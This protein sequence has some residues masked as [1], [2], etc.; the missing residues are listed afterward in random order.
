MSG[1]IRVDIAQACI[2]AADANCTI[3]VAAA[4]TISFNLEQQ[5]STK[6][7]PKRYY[8]ENGMGFHEDDRIRVKNDK[9]EQQ[10]KARLE[11]GE[12]DVRLNGVTLEEIQ[13]ALRDHG[14]EATLVYGNS[15]TVTRPQ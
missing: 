2:N 10:Q 5:M 12:L 13:E 3:A 14:I 11:R 8:E 7:M 4:F 6:H 15:V 9:F 1:H